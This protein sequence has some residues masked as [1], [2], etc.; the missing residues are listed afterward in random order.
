MSPEIFFEYIDGLLL[1]AFIVACVLILAVNIFGLG[2]K[3]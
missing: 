3:D 2:V 1:R